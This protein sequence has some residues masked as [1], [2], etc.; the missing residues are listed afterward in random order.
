VQGKVKLTLE[1]WHDVS[2]DLFSSG[3]QEM[4]RQD[5]PEGKSQM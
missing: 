2:G 5:Y 4:T 3:T 1:A